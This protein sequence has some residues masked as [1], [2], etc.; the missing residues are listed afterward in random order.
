MSE[1][2]D[3]AVRELR[4]RLRELPAPE[5]V[6]DEATYR[7]ERELA[8]AASP[9]RRENFERYQ[10]SKRRHAELDYLPIKLDIEN[11]SR[12]NFRCTMCVV[13]DW[14]KGQRA[15]DLP[16]DS[17][18][19]LIDEQYGLLEIKLQGIGEPTLQRDPYFEMIRY[20]R[21]QHIWVRT[22]TNASLLHL[23][24]NYRKLIDSGVN[25]VQISIDGADKETFEKIR[26]GSVFERVAEN[27]KTI[28]A[29]CREKGISR[30]KMWTVVQAGNQHQLPEFV[31][32]AQ[33]L[34]FETQ[35]FSLNLSD[36]G[37]SEWNE[38]NDLVNV[39]DHMDVDRLLE[40]V[41]RGKERGVR[42]RFWNVNEKYSLGS[43]ETLCPW[44]FE[45]AY[46]ASDQRVSPCC[47]LGNPDVYE[48][49][50]GIQEGFNP[51]WN[52][53]AFEDFR[54]AH[55]DGRIPDVCRGCYAKPESN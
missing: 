43:P 36:W 5:P 29:Y 49:G 15:V 34:G 25:E 44:P 8:L 48:I 10:A 18:K 21:A 37:I 19:S 39:Q 30:T 32:F 13:S 40:L 38:R 28:N 22:T 42:V 27:C 6:P 11:V 14:D 26:R 45:R 47:Y 31:D 35:V 53:E 55:L 12:C 4:R 1:T 16:V 46:I 7:A 41:E 20:A 9:R 17:F 3:P 54:Q 33:E 50:D 23:N 24:D 2:L 51:I 52:G